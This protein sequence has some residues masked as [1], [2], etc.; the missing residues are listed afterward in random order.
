MTKYTAEAATELGVGRGPNG[1]G[2]RPV[3]KGAFTVDP[4]GRRVRA[5]TGPDALQK[6]QAWA[7]VRNEQTGA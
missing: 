3:I 4:N 6:A 2:R 7:D 5:F 1:T